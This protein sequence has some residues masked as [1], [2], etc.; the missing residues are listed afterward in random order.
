MSQVVFKEI[1][2]KMKKSLESLR[3]DFMS[4]R[5]GR[6]STALLDNIKVDY[7]GTLVPISQLASL[8]VPEARTIEI[9]PWDKA[10]MV[11][12]DKAI[13]KSDLGLTPANDGKVLRINLPQPTQERRQELVKVVKKMAEETRI[14]FRSIR[15]EGNEKVKEQEKKKELSE[16]DSKKAQTHIQKITDDHIKKVD[17]VLTAKEKE[18]MEV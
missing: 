11:E 5:T 3:K 2:D 15:R 1:E 13:A 7:Y 8:S 12:I 9:K 17:E 16:D 6:A 18:I 10:S 4:I 14:S